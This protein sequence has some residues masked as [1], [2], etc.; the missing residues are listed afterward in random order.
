MEQK[1]RACKACGKEVAA[2]AKSCPHCG[3]KI[4]NGNPVLAGVLIVVVLAIVIGAVVGNDKPTRVDGNLSV[5]PSSSEVETTSA[6]SDIFKVGETVKLHDVVV[7]MVNVTE[8][9]GSTY[10]K[11]TDGNVYVLCEFEIANNSSEDVAVSSLLSFKAYCDD[12]T[13]NFSL[14]ALMEKGNKNQLDGTVAAGKKFNGVIGYEVPA[15]W[16]ELE[17]QFTPDFW[18]GKDI[19]FVATNG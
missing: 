19:T 8:S 6:R 9:T 13:C 16:K 17:V 2:S 14:K 3:A 15:D 5:Q 1:L 7:S 18:S 10:N 4:K 11:P 12:Y